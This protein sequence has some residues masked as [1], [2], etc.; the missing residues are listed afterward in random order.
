MNLNFSNHKYWIATGITFLAVIIF[1]YPYGIYNSLTYE[2][3]REDA[4]HIA[5]NFLK[6]QSININGFYTE[7]FTETYQVENKYYLKVL[8]LNEYKKIAQDKNWPTRGWLIYFHQNLGKE[9]PQTSYYVTISHDGHIIGF[10]TDLPNTL[11]IASVKENE[12]LLMMKNYL[13]EK[14]KLNL[15]SFTLVQSKQDNLGKR[16]DYYFNWEQKVTSPEGK[17]KISGAVQGNLV[18]SFSRNFEVPETERKYFEAGQILF[19]TGS[20]IFVIILMIVAFF[21]FIKK[22]HQG[23][24]WFSMGR[25]LFLMYFILSFLMLVNIWPGIGR[26]TSV[27]NLSFLN[28]KIIIFAI[29]G[30]IVYFFI[31][32][33]LFACWAVG[34]SYAR[35]LWPE[36]LQGID[37]FVK[38]HITSIATGTS[39]MRG[40]VLGLGF[41]L[42][43]C[44][45]P[46]VLN[47]PNSAMF[48]LQ[49]KPLQMYG[50]YFPAVD[51]ILDAFTSAAL[52]SIVITFF[53][54]N[55]SYQRWKRKWISILLA[56]LVTMLATVIAQTPPSLNNFVLDLL[57]YFIFGCIVGYVYFLFDLL[58]IGSF[59]FH[60]S[61]MAKALVLSAGT[62]SFYHIN[63]A[64]IVIAFLITPVIYLISRIRKKEF[65]IENYGLPSHIQRISE[66]ERLK[67]EL[68]IAAK[69]Q[70]SL[71]PKEEPKIPGYDIAAISIPAVEAGGDYFDFVKLSGEKLG[72][73]IGDVS[74]KGVG[75][76]IYMTLTKGILQAHAEEDVSPK[77]VLG[78]VNRLLY[79]TIE[80][81]SFVSMF[82]AILD[83][84]LST[85]LYSR[86]GH[87]PGILCSPVNGTTKLLLSKGMALGLE[88]G[89]IF[90]E[91]LF[92]ENISLNHGDVFVLYTDGF[93]EAMNER[94][95]L[96]GEERLIKLIEENKTLS[97][98]DLLNLIL[99]EVRRFVDNYPQHDDMTL[100]ILKR[101]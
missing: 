60:S 5:K 83:T 17:W 93:T 49:S 74:G 27:G 16:I 61:L 33:L 29:N 87:N 7:S 58:T 26:G 66:R 94:E 68:E 70:L 100:V 59:L 20:V 97:S 44:I 52:S 79:K 64:F 51:T 40:M 80:K 1:L 4:I 65:V 25:N 89:H 99:K 24:V 31:S 92:E 101:I 45:A 98:R 73:A 48:V 22:Y 54:I 9:L 81:N 96:Y 63:L 3:T 56:G 34:E 2:T 35:S 84:K 55:I 28:V 76:A 88:E 21:L 53:I 85:I 62:N 41:A 42:V 6:D 47:T 32:V 23:E 38:G 19:G 71:L 78:K 67:K 72:I 30:L 37:G 43:N 36:K 46:L 90:T 86:A 12:A 82:Y 69:V 39:L 57:S 15:D 18:S 13:T 8:G 75:A 95:E 14:A 10:E 91:T 11:E 77:N 50:G